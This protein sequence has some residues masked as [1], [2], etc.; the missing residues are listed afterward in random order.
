[1]PCT[2]VASC[3]NGYL[4]YVPSAYGYLHGCYEADSS[5]VQPGSGERFAYAL[6]RML[7]SL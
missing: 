6:V 3:C 2:V 5:R 1:M 7:R 4:N